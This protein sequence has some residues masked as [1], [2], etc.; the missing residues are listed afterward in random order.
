MRGEFERASDDGEPSGSAGAPIQQ[1]IA[2]SGLTNVLVVVVR[3]YGGRKLGVGGLVRAYGGAAGDA[4]AR[5]PTRVRTIRARVH[6]RFAYP[7][8]S[9]AM[10]VISQFDCRT[11]ETHYGD[12]TRLTLAIRASTAGAFVDAFTEALAGRGDAR[13]EPGGGVVSD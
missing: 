2:T 1:R 10:H 4:L 6:I 11:V 8:T 5:V 13:I 12:D 3:Y 9:P 7:D